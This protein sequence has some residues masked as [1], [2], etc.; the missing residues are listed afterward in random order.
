M[1]NHRRKRL[2]IPLTVAAAVFAAVN[3]FAAE[4]DEVTEL[5][6]PESTVQ[7]GVGYVDHDNQRFGQYS[8]LNEKGVYGLLDIDVVRRDDDTGTW[9][10]LT[11]RNLGLDS[12]ELRVEHNRQG[13]WGYLLDYSQ[14][15]RFN[16]FTVNTGLSGIGTPDVTINGEP[17]RD[18][19]LKTERDRLTLGFDKWLQGGFSFNLTFRN[20]EK[21]GARMFGR[22]T[23]GAMEFL[24]EPINQTTRQIEATLNYTGMRLQLS[25]GYYGTMFDN[26]NPALNITGGDAALSGG[27]SPFTPIALPPDNQSHQL[28][29][30]GGYTFTPTTRGTFKLAYA[31]Q[32][33]DD[34]FIVPASVGRTDLGGRIDTGSMQMGITARPM[35]KLSLLANYRY[36][37]K[38]DKT[39]VVDYFPVTVTTTAT[40]ENEPRSIK[41]TVGKV[42]ASYQLPANF[43]LTAGVDEEIKKRNT[44]AV[45]VVSFREETDETSYRLELR[46]SMSETVTGAV[47]YIHSNRTG[48]DFQTTTL[49]TGATGS[50]LIAPIHLADRDRDKVRLS[51]SWTPTDPLSLQFIA[52]RANDEY[53]ARTSQDLGPRSGNA[54]FYS[55]DGAYTFSDT[56]QGTA[57]VSRNDNRMD[58][59]TCVNA[60]TAGVCPATVAS[61]VWEAKLRNQGNAVGLGMRGKFSSNL[62][63][64]TDIQY[65]AIQDEFGQ[66]AITPATASVSSLPDIHTKLTTVR[67]YT[68]YTL[69]KNAGLRVDYT[70][71]RYR[72]DDWTW[73]NFTYTD[74]TTVSQQPKQIVHFIGVS[75]YYRWQ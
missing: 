21:D 38:N 46:R 47:A 31:H 70:Y 57:W 7:A 58:Q 2:E 12:R 32:T 33:Q 19:Q 75:Y 30:T 71:D 28:F 74:G 59:A 39:P 13:D 20:E 6:K 61:P 72:T 67:L 45:R 69:Q 25:G 52:E 64:G 40:G 60:A 22:G 53:S 73:T 37:N 49:T 4:G 34:S 35:P 63:V 68:R 23:P 14:I 44:S 26:H 16:P 10:R 66:Q 41:T 17:R 62:E 43:R 48:S 55:I 51:A 18:V 42:E 54:E 36:E 5:T 3:T 15:P 24:A 11:G 27:A 8:G 56:W 1:N 29:L 9:L 50:N 65:M